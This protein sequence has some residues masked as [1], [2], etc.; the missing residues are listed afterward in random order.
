MTARWLG[1]ISQRQPSDERRSSGGERVKG[2]SEEK[3]KQWRNI[4][5]E[6]QEK[7]SSFCWL[8]S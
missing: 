7:K 6:R 8:A 4:I 2:R 5:Q 1:K 3:M